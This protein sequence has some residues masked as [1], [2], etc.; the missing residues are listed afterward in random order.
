MIQ[1]YCKNKFIWLRIVKYAFKIKY[2][3]VHMLISGETNSY[4]KYIIMGGWLLAFIHI[5]N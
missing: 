3:P 4:T 5:K 1:W 2:L